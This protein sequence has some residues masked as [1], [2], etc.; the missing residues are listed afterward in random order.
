MTSFSKIVKTEVMKKQ[1][2]FLA[3]KTILTSL[4]KMLVTPNFLTNQ[5]LIIEGSSKEIL[6][7][8]QK[9]INEVYQFQSQLIV[10]E[11]IIFAKKVVMYKL[12]VTTII[13]ALIADKIITLDWKIPQFKINFQKITSEINKR[14]FIAGAF[15][16]GG[17]INSPNISKYHLE[18]QGPDLE[19]VKALQKLINS[20][21]FQLK[22]ILRRNK[23]LLYSKKSTEIA[24]FLKLIDATLSLLTFE[25][26]RI[27]RDMYNSINRLTNIE[28]SN[29]QKTNLAAQ[30]QIKMINF[31]KRIGY[32]S[33]LDLRTQQI[34]KIRLANPEASLSELCDFYEELCHNKIS[35]SGINHIMREIKNSYLVFKNNNRSQKEE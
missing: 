5:K 26:E 19:F 33:K 35:K 23:P 14:A 13:S 15:I 2:Y 21:G 16:A 7:F 3:K 22:I 24:D 32:F 11:K 28:I 10:T 8:V 18:I 4:I 31:L 34:A 1:F 25:N 27:E 30:Q 20:F 12:E 9:L 6:L 29:Q 17:S